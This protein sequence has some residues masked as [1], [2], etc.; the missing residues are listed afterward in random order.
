MTTKQSVGGV[1]VL[2][3]VGAVVL[4][5]M[6]LHQRSVPMM[7][8]SGGIQEE[9]SLEKSQGVY[10]I[11]VKVNDITLSFV[12]DTGAADVQI[13]A[14][15]VKTLQEKGTITA[16]DQR[17]PGIYRDA[18]GREE[19]HPRYLIHSI[20]VGNLVMKNVIASVA[21]SPNANLLLGQ[22]FLERLPR[23]SLDSTRR[24]LVI[25]NHN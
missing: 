25:D 10:M 23:W 22:T 2:A 9:I 24:V 20:T 16:S 1:V 6:I 14:D 4:S 11:P 5:P 17:E 18:T 15:T 8:L 7:T 19:T 12:F 13:T 21:A 3:L